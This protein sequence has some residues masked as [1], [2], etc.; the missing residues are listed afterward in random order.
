MPVS[1]RDPFPDSV[2]QEQAADTLPPEGR[3]HGGGIEII[4]SRI[5][6]EVVPRVF[7]EKLRPIAPESLVAKFPVDILPLGVTVSK[8]WKCIAA[9]MHLAKKAASSGRASRTNGLKSLIRS[10][11]LERLKIHNF[12][13]SRPQIRLQNKVRGGAPVKKAALRAA[14]CGNNWIRTSDPM[15]VRN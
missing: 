15:L 7:R 6:L 8:S 12:Q 4:L 11:R 3:Q 10:P 5:C 9:I 14:L 2:F 13:H 1:E